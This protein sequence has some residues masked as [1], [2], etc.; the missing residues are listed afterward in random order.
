ME[1]ERRLAA[2]RRIVQTGQADT[3]A[4]LRR[5]LK[6]KGY[7]VDQSTL[8]RDLAELGI[9]KRGGRYVTDAPDAPADPLD[10]NARLAGTVHRFTVC[11]PHLI[12][13]HT[14]VGAAQ[15]ISVAIDR[16]EEPAIVATLAGDDT[17]FLATK[18]RRSQAVALRRLSQWFGEKNE[19]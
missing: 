7:V 15:P 9:R 10:L 8:S 19:S 1:R 6:K 2:L 14:A 16:A 18:N 12:V 3:Q 17:I 4:R 13:I 11:G 5:A